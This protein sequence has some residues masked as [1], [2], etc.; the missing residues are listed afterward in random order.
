MYARAI[1]HI[2]IDRL[3]KRV[4][5]LK[6]HSHF[7]TQLNGINFGVIN[8]FAIDANVAFDP[9]DI[10]RVVHAVDTAQESG[11]STPR[12]SDER[13]HGFVFNGDVYIFDGVCVR[14]IDL[15]TFCRNFHFVLAH[16]ALQYVQIVHVSALLPA[17]FKS[18][19]QD[20]GHC[21]HRDQENQ[22]YDNAA[23]SPFIIGRI[24]PF[25]PFIDLR[26]HR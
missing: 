14:V 9:A 20:N 10:N 2:V 11:F 17:T 25:G 26:R 21:I 12:G 7:G 24:G 22:Q 13:R 23:P 5:F 3:G 6:H 4:W 8:I 19:A 16:A 15:H 1:G 18:A